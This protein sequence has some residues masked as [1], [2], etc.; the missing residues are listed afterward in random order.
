MANPFDSMID[1]IKRVGYHNHR[2]EEHSDLVS[3]QIWQDLLAQC[4]ALRDDVKAGAVEKWLNVKAPG[5]RH[6]RIDLFVGQPGED[7]YADLRRVRIGVENKSVITA[8]RNRT[9]RYDD[10]SEVMN[11]VLAVRPEAVLAAVVVVGFAERVLNVPDKVKTLAHDFDREVAPRLG[12][13]DVTLWEEYAKAIS[14]NKPDDP[15]KTIAKFQTLPTRTHAR[16]HEVGLD[17][18]LIVPVYVDNVNPPRLLDKS[19]SGIDV[20]ADYRRM[21]EHLCRAYTARWHS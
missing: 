21:V 17:C 2:T 11:S 12:T 3:L 6:R 1:A 14:K 16:T 10:I 8:H 7:G 20:E 13:G 5:G 9:N 18:L 4:P 15:H 19:E